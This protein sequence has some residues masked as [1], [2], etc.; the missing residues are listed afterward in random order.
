MDTLIKDIRYGIRAL[1]QHPAFA[2]I[3]VITLALGIGAN[4]AIF[5]VV[6]AVLLRPLPYKDPARLLLVQESLPKLGW[7]YGGIAAAETLDYMAG[8]EG[9]SEM[10]AYTTLN[11]NLTG[12]GEA[13]RVQAARVS[14]SLSPLLGVSPILGRAFAPDEDKPGTNIIILG[15]AFWRRAFGG[16][17]NIIGQVV[18]LDEKPYTIIGVMPERVQFPYIDATFA[19][20]VELWLPLALSD[21]ERASRANNL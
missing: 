21:E 16:D 18:K 12:Q 3:V 8:N 14:P 6:N 11:F 7:N 19:E 2:V 13:R 20:P 10:A 4:T 15:G 5:S 1:V 17:A 9:F